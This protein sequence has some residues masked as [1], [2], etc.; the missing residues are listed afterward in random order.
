MKRSN[1]LDVKREQFEIQRLKENLYC[2]TFNPR[3]RFLPD[4]YEILVNKSSR[5]FDLIYH[6]D[7]SVSCDWW[8][9]SYLAQVC[10]IYDG[11]YLT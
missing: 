1:F 11:N 6:V 5:F 7:F 8:N 10:Q 3:N 4:K 9:I 2:V